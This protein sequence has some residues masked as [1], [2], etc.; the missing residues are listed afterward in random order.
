MGSAPYPLMASSGHD[1]SCPYND[2]CDD[3]SVAL[4]CTH[5]GAP[6]D[7]SADDGGC[8]DERRPA[9][10]AVS[11]GSELVLSIRP[12]FVSAPLPFGDAL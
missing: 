4:Q 9:G 10:G 2:A 6:L 11:G 5:A 12:Q 7:D 3:G 8:N 1:R